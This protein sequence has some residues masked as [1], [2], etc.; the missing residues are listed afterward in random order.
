MKHIFLYILT[1]DQISI[2]KFI[3]LYMVIF[4]LLFSWPASCVLG[5][6]RVYPKYGDIPGAWASGTIDAN[7]FLEV[8]LLFCSP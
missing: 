8:V 5:P 6:P 1:L 2:R 4:F 7:Q 3:T